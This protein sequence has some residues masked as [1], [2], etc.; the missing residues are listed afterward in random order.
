MTLIVPVFTLTERGQ[1]TKLKTGAA[2]SVKEITSFHPHKE[3]NF[4]SQFQ[5]NINI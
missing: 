3:N 4:F 5:E 1:R 2:K